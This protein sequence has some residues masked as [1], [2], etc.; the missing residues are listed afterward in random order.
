MKSETPRTDELRN[1]YNSLQISEEDEIFDSHAEIEREL[2]IAKVHC[3]D[4]NKG[5]RINAKLNAILIKKNLE[6][7]ERIEDL[8]NNSKPLTLA[9]NVQKNTADSLR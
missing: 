3:A 8:S 5:A 9:V 2:I 1:R 4:A 6:L 7:K